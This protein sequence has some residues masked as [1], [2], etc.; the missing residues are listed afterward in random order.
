M[1][2]EH[3]NEQEATVHLTQVVDG[4]VQKLHLCEHCAAKAGFDLEGPISISDILMGLG[5]SSDQA[6]DELS[7]LRVQ[8]C[9][10]CGMTR[11]EF[12]K[13]GRVGCANCYASF[14]PELLSIL[15]AVHHAESHCGK[16]P[17]SLRERLGRTQ[18]IALLKDSLQKAVAEERFEEAAS[19]RDRIRSLL[20]R[21]EA[22]V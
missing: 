8:A 16:I 9:S 17:E 19:I 21:K 1:I 5:P 11:Q 14:E 6:A 10:Q 22:G 7:V 12:K 3:C 15:K 2:C 4:D 18:E 13:R 20:D